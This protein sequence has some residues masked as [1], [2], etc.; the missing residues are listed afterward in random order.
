MILP[1]GSVQRMP[2]SG[3]VL[4]IA[5]GA[6]DPYVYFELTNRRSQI[7]RLAANHSG[8][9][10]YVASWVRIQPSLQMDAGW[11]SSATIER[12]PAAIPQSGYQKTA[13]RPHLP[14][15][16]TICRTF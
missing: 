6:Q 14:E 7:V 11:L 10:E 1:G 16:P 9:P 12:T 15:A 4:S 5:G 13:P 2:E 8:R 3:D